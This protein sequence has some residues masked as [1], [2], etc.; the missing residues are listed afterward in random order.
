MT[1]DAIG[2][3]LALLRDNLERLDE[4]ARADFEAF[5]ADFRNLDSALHRLQTSIQILID[6]GGLGVARRGLGTP[7]TSRDILE[8][9]EA[10]GIIPEGSLERFGP[11]FG[12]R[13]RVVQLYDQIDP[14]IVYQALIDERQDLREL[15]RLLVMALDA[16]SE[17]SGR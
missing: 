6:L 11:I 15:A 17:G 13:N 8:K 14:H 12:F 2:T 4:L 3:K 5:S 16:Q 10:S 9:L 7:S 1:D